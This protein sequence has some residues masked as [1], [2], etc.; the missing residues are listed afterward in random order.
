LFTLLTHGCYVCRPLISEVKD[1]VKAKSVEPKYKIVQEPTTGHPDYLIAEVT[2]V[3]TRVV[4][5]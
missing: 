5:G 4:I 3:L 2:N 1:K